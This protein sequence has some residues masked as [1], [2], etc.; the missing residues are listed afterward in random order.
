MHNDK[1]QEDKKTYSAPTL[2]KREKLVEV[3]EGGEP[4]G[5]GVT[6]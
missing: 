5:G 4:I 3:T 6:P 1:N 2:E